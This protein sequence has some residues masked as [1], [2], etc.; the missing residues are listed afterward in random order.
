MPITGSCHCGDITFSIDGEIPPKLT[1]CTCSICSKRGALYAYYAPERFRVQAK[2]DSDSIYR[3]NT[4]HVAH[5]FCA[6]C[7]CFVYLDSPAYDHD[8]SWD[9]KTRRIG[10]IARLFGGFDAAEAPNIPL[11]EVRE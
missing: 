2:P 4:M 7:G 8:R 5:H 10:V 3:W 9:G 11:I 1:R 6:R